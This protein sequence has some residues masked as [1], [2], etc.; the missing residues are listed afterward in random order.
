MHDASE[1]LPVDPPARVLVVDDEEDFREVFASLLEQLGLEVT[2]AS[3]GAEGLELAQSVPFSLILLDQ[4]MPGLTGL[5]VAARL[6]ATGIETP[7]A[8]V[9]AA[10]DIADVARTMGTTLWL[11]KP[12]G[13]T[14]LEHLLAQAGLPT[15]DPAGP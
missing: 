11:R 15:Q 14:A 1:P 6:R 5:D 7:I 9:S 4:R 2:T 12:F 13:L 8:A 10:Q 3:S